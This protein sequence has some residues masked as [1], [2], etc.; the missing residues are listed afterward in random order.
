MPVYDYLCNDC[1]KTF[2]QMLTIREHD[3]QQIKCPYCR[4]T[5]V[6]Q[7]AAA[8]YAVTSKKSA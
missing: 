3:G 7:V 1:H 2:E 8:F 5:N 6:V 4:S